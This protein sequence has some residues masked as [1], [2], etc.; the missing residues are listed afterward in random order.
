MS[1]LCTNIKVKIIQHEAVDAGRQQGSQLGDPEK[2]WVGD[3]LLVWHVFKTF[4]SSYSFH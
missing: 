2:L 4:Q 3:A 1:H